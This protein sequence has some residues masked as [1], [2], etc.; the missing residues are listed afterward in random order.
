M[1]AGPRARRSLGRGCSGDS[2]NTQR[3]RSR[4]EVYARDRKPYLRAARPRRHLHLFHGSGGW[5]LATEWSDRREGDQPAWLLD[6]HLAV[7]LRRGDGRRAVGG[8][9]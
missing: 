8:L 3:R 5:I 9:G 1:I 4:S 2:L 7:R 6:P